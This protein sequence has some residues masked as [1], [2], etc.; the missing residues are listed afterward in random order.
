[1]SVRGRR[2]LQSGLLACT[3]RNSMLVYL[4][5]SLLGLPLAVAVVDRVRP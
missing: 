1:M 4:M 2:L 3:R 5:I